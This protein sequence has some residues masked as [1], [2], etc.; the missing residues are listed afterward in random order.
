MPYQQTG[1]FIFFFFNTDL[2]QKIAT[3]TKTLVKMVERAPKRRLDLSAFVLPNGAAS[4]VAVPVSLAFHFLGL[5][6]E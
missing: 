1:S 2:L 6:N 4:T 3:V 5:F